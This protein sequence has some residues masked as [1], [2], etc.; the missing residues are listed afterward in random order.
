MVDSTDLRLA[1]VVAVKVADTL[2]N[3]AFSRDAAG[4]PVVLEQA[5]R[6][7]RCHLESHVGSDD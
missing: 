6:I 5:R 7:V 3:V 4:D 2:V 1:L